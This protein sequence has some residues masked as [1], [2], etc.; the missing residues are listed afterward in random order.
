MRKCIFDDITRRALDFSAAEEAIRKLTA[1]DKMLEVERLAA[2][3]AKQ[4]GLSAMQRQLEESQ[5][6]SH[7]LLSLAEQ[8]NSLRRV[9][10]QALGSAAARHLDTL[11]GRTLI[12]NTDFENLRRVAATAMDYVS[13]YRGTVGDVMTQT[14]EGLDFRNRVIE[15]S[16]SRVAQ[17]A[18]LI[19][20]SMT[21]AF[22]DELSQV[23]K[24]IIDNYD[25]LRA[26][27]HDLAAKE[28]HRIT[29]GIREAQLAAFP[30]V[31]AM[32]DHMADALRMQLPAAVSDATFAGEMF[33]RL[34]R[35]EAITSESEGE[36][37]LNELLVWLWG[38]FQLLP[39]KKIVLQAL[40]DILLVIIAQMVSNRDDDS[41]EQR[42]N[43]TMSQIEQR[44][45]EKMAHSQEAV[46][47]KLEEFR[48]TAN[49]RRHSV[50]TAKVPMRA[51][52][53]T[54]ARKIKSLSPNMMVEELEQQGQ[55]LHVEFFDYT[56]GNLKQGWVYKRHLE[57]VE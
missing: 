32:A 42:L 21:S 31:V 35:A 20:R 56:D 48:Q 23:T 17:D 34:Q 7:S 49:S 38:K 22:N 30:S 5:K 14:T 43:K 15:D 25:L 3:M 37:F 36:E 46:L 55:W 52:P 26:A 27:R 24:G 51:K 57:L 54:Q 19:L 40:F 45:E 2:K 11:R 8:G 53:T 13:Q 18:T 4:S 39:P 41:R 1:V 44:V 10:V 29:A 47:R 6:I 9:E 16:L 50:V 33:D 28:F 12:E